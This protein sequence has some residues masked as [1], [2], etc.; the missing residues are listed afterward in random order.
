MPARAAARF[1]GIKHC[2]VT[3]ALAVTLISTV[4]A[5]TR[6]EVFK[7]A[8]CGC[9]EKWAEHL[10]QTG[11]QVTVREVKD[12]GAERNRLGISDSLG[13]CHSAT[14]EGYALEGHVPS[15]DILRL[16]KDKPKALGLAVPGMPASAPG[17][18]GPTMP[19]ETL[20]VYANGSSRVF[21]KH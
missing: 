2:L 4:H 12:V 3:A 18:D 14:V 15:A 21:A 11:F 9:C 5:A 20:L 17:M 19:F 10:R 6:I 1:P 16:L 8:Y 13:S 7:S